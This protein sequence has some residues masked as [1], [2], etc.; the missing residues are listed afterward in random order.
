MANDEARTVA[1]DAAAT[2]FDV[3][4]K[5]TDAEGDII[6]ITGLDDALN[7]TTAVVE[8]AP[9]QVSYTPDAGYCNDPGAAP[10]DTFTY[11][12]TGGDTATVSVTVTCP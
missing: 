5:D 7:G 11:T 9:D 1:Q 8:G 4:S 12:V 10:E 3:L 2:S 6:E